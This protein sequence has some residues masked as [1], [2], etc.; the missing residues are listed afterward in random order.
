MIALITGASKGIGKELAIEFAKHK[1]DLILVARSQL[2]LKK[3]SKKLTEDFKIRTYVISIDLSIPNNAEKLYEDVAN[4]GLSVDYLINNAGFGDQGEFAEANLQKQVN[5]INLNVLTLTK[6]THLFVQ[7]MKKKRQGKILN[8][9]STASFQPGPSMSVYFA[10]KHYVL[11]FTEAIAEELKPYG[12]QVSA[13]C[14]G[15]TESEFAATAGFT[16][17][18]NAKPNRFPSSK[19]VAKFGYAKFMAGKVIS[20]H[21][22]FNTVQAVLA[23]LAPRSIVRKIAYLKIK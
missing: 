21:G 1:T 23:Q 16:M 22:W 18:E 7:Q 12:I 11:A 5:M 13:L 8:L 9:A 20:I 19:E 14:P 10:T 17:L 2:L 6:L 15:P 4:L 3:L